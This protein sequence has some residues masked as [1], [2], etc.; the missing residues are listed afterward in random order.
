[1]SLPTS[2]L[3]WRIP[4]TDIWCPP[5]GYRIADNVCL[6]APRFSPLPKKYCAQAQGICDECKTP[7]GLD[8]FGVICYCGQQF[9]AHRV[10]C[11]A[12]LFKG[13]CAHCH[14]NLNASTPI[15][16]VITPASALRTLNQESK[17][18]NEVHEAE[19]E[20]HGKKVKKQR[21]RWKRGS[22][23]LVKM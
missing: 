22:L 2:N 14:R 4:G 15:T 23:R 1:M 3:M 9:K 19:N 12:K 18:E 20:V 21:P 5:P 8:T 6:P 16:P 17:A 11:I 7:L 13:D 10:D